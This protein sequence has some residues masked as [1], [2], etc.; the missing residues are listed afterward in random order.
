MVSERSSRGE[1]A[2][3]DVAL[4]GCFLQPVR[5]LV[6]SQL[7]QQSELP[8]TLVTVQQ[9]VRVVLLS[10]PQLVGQ[11]VFLQTLGL[12]ETFIAG[13]AGE[14]FDVTGDMFPQ[15]VFL[16]ETFVTQLTEEPF[17]FVQLP[18]PLPVL[19]FLLLFTQSCTRK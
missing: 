15:L 1:G 11:L 8:V 5:C 9:L 19:L 2:F 7:P 16:M 3:T 18:P 10:L 6:D 14:R 4:Q 12:V 17:L 13:A